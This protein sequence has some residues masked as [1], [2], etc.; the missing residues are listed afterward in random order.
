[1]TFVTL[2]INRKIPFAT[3]VISP[4]PS[5]DL[6]KAIECPHDEPNQ[7]DWEELDKSAAVYAWKAATIT[8]ECIPGVDMF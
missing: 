6:A 7:G 2:I 1:M 3:K 8:I 5:D 4:D